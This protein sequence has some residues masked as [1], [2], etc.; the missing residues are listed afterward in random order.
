MNSVK[1][2][3]RSSNSSETNWFLRNAKSIKDAVF[4]LAGGLSDEIS[5]LNQIGI[6]PKV[7]IVDQEK[8]LPTSLP[9]NELV[10]EKSAAKAIKIAKI[11]KEKKAV[12]DIII[13]CE[14]VIILD[15]EII[16]RPK[17]SDAALSILSRLNNR[18][19][20]SF[21]G[22][23][24]IDSSH[25]IIKFHVKT[26]IK[27]CDVPIEMYQEYVKSREWFNQTGAYSIRG[28]GV[29]FVECFNGV[30]PGIPVYKLIQ[31]IREL[32][33][34][35]KS[36]LNT[37]SP[38]STIKHRP[39]PL[40]R[41]I[42]LVSN[43][44]SVNTD[45]NKTVETM[46]KNECYG[47]PCIYQPSLKDSV[48]NKTVVKEKDGHKYA[49]QWANVSG[50]KIIKKKEEETRLNATPSKKEHRYTCI[51]A[52]ASGDESCEITIKE[53]DEDE[54]EFPKYYQNV[55]GYVRSTDFTNAY[56]VSDFNDVEITSDPFG[57]PK[58]PSELVTLPY[59][60]SPNPSKI[61]FHASQNTPSF[62]HH[63][64]LH[65]NKEYG[66][67]S[68]RTMIS[69]EELFKSRQQHRPQPQSSQS[70]QHDFRQHL[71]PKDISTNY[72][73]IGRP[74]SSNLH[75]MGIQPKLHPN[76]S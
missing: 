55:Q 36:S 74:G 23:T 26:D 56:P 47:A 43:L 22:V 30:L 17:D 60:N 45:T 69:A 27:F 21:T 54:E 48:S 58:T 2:K 3:Q 5:I 64:R 51:Y 53:E 19:H 71:S 33:L 15:G 38:T 8:L 76:Y 42:S 28:K 66:L 35:P 40:P 20:S 46:K 44:D 12:Y 24:L 34:S 4:V 49:T 32:L 39:I 70:V 62:H 68:H 67:E 41:T 9:P 29:T 11:L 65:Q 10:E 72:R 13:G 7:V 52:T 37:T 31:K 63:Q 61:P 6:E 25:R 18:W 75:R 50:E 14:S 57:L 73:G 1:E 16:G 59:I